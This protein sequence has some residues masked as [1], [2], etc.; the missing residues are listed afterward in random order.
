MNSH[1]TVIHR[2]ST[3]HRK[4]EYLNL[5]NGMINTKIKITMQTFTNILTK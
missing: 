2:L 5:E 4:K 1:K 3:K